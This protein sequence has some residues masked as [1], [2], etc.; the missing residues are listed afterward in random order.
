MEDKLH[1][2][3]CKVFTFDNIIK[4]FSLSMNYDEID[5]ACIYKN[6]LFK[7]CFL[8]NANSVKVENI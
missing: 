6:L 5:E 2:D 4:I 8:S 1:Q 3:L 7:Y